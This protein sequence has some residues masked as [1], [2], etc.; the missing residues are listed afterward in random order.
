MVSSCHNT[1]KDDTVEVYID[2]KL[3]KSCVYENLPLI[4]KGDLWITNKGGFDGRL[5]P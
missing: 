2:G 3:S 4:S 1:V 5:N